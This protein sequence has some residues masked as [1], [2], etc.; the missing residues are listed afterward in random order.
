MAIFKK[1]CLLAIGFMALGAAGTVYA[2]NPSTAQP[3]AKTGET[4]PK[5]KG[6]AKAKPKEAAAP[7]PTQPADSAPSTEV[8]K[9]EPEVTYRLAKLTPRARSV[10]HKDTD[11]DQTDQ[12]YAIV[13]FSKVLDYQHEVV[14]VPRFRTDRKNP[15]ASDTD[16]IEQAYVES[17][18]S[19]RFSFTAGKKSE[20]EGPGFI[21]NPSDLLNEGQEVFDRMYQNDGKV[22]L[23]L[24]YRLDDLSLGIGYI[25]RR[26]QEVGAGKGWFQASKEVFHTDLRLQVTSNAAEKSTVGMSAQRFIGAALEVHYDGRYQRRQ[27]NQEVGL[28]GPD[29]FSAYG[30]DDKGSYTDDSPSTYNLIGSR[31]VFTPKRTLIVEYIQNQAGLESLDFKSYYGSQRDRLAAGQSTN[32]APKV[33]LG[34]HYVFTAL[35]DEE[36]LKAVK[37]GAYYLANTDDQSAFT[38]LSLK[39]AV[40]ALTTFEV[41]PT[42]F[43]GDADTEFGERPFSQ[44]TYLVFTGR[45]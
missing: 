40:S 41:Q 23:R 19:S 18:L 27:R 13:R 25:P 42:W 32:E 29:Q 7:E 22:F 15:V 38:S 21:V 31:L 43:T 4:K 6:K 1:S 20:I 30:G 24:R 9:I 37:L 35:Q 45:F 2:Q 26:A 34:R 33:L 17:A 39:Y 28:L 5:K 14:F 44:A 10:F 16:F 36:S 11:L 3:A 12:L 8:T